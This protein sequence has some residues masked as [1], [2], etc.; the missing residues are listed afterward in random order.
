MAVMSCGTWKVRGG[1]WV[2]GVDEAGGAAGS[3][4]DIGSPGA[5]IDLGRTVAELEAR[6][7][8]TGGLMKIF[9]G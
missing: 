9:Y 7:A 6:L 8:E 1:A 4:V 3:V 2:D 5:R